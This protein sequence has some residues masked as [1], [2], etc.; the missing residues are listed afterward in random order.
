MVLLPAQR[1]AWELE[2]R[3]HRRCTIVV[4]SRIDGPERILSTDD[5]GG[6][7][8]AR[9]AD[10]LTAGGEGEPQLVTGVAPALP[11]GVRGGS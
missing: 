7:A 10:P 5:G 9:S 6:A 4:Q 11:P 8:P 3:I 2:Q 1:G